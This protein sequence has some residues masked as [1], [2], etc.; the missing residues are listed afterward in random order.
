MEYNIDWMKEEIK[1]RRYDD[2]WTPIYLYNIIDFEPNIPGI[3]NVI[4]SDHSERTFIISFNFENPIL[5]EK[6]LKCNLT[7]SIKMESL[8]SIKKHNII[9]EP[10]NNKTI[11]C[12][13]IVLDDINYLNALDFSYNRISYILSTWSVFL[14][15]SL[16]INKITIYD[17]KHQVNLIFTSSILSFFTQT[18]DLLIPIVSD[19]TDPY[20]ILLSL[21]RES[22]NSFSPF[23][24]VL[25]CYKIIEAIN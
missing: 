8:S 25:C 7:S 9:I 16:M 13:M 23:Y 5:N 11:D 21:F 14:G 10:K 4:S 17:T 6:F 1:F 24:K 3:Y 2:L 20:N 15:A 18:V 22:R 12:I 19:V